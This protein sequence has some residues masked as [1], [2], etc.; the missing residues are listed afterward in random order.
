MIFRRKGKNDE[1]ETGETLDET[2]TADVRAE[3]P[4][5]STEVD[6]ADL[7]AEDRIDL[8]ALVVTGM[9]G[10]ELGLQ[11]DE[12]SGV[13]QAVLLM[14]DDSALELRAFAA[15][16]T[17]GIWDEVRQ[18]IAGEAARMGG[19]ATES[20]GPFGTELVLVVPVE[21]PEGQVFSQTSRVIGVDGPRWLLRGTILGRAAVE[22]DAAEPMEAT[23]RNVVVVRGNE[24]MAVRESLPL[25][26]PP[27]AQPNEPEEA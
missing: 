1:P 27:G 23:L 24:P 19:T 18:E 13:V 21:D 5:D 25:Q 8:G 7:E 12:G 15:P 11:V 17:S 26:M 3:G 10:M 6:A 14:L 16:K 9:P 4:F 2:G 22:E 20:E